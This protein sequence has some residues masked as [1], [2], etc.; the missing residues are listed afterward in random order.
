M[1]A[2]CS[3]ASSASFRTSSDM[4]ICLRSCGFRTCKSIQSHNR[5]FGHDCGKRR[6]AGS[7][8]ARYRRPVERFQQGVWADAEPC[9][10]HGRCRTDRNPDLR[11]AEAVCRDQMRGTYRRSRVICVF[12]R[13]PGG[14]WA[15]AGCDLPDG[16]GYARDNLRDLSVFADGS[17]RGPDVSVDRQAAGEAEFHHAA[18]GFCANLSEAGVQIS[19]ILSQ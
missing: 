9:Q 4:G 17:G 14:A 13:A 3:L 15:G 5:R 12:G 8:A 2:R 10:S 1:S 16:R 19:R 11:T 7:G 18:C 6:R